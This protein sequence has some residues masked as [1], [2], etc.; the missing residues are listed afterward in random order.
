MAHISLWINVGLDYL[1]SMIVTSFKSSSGDR[2]PDA[3]VV[4]C[5]LITESLIS[6]LTLTDVNCKKMSHQSTGLV[7]IC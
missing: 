6:S 3:K 4:T 1:H 5:R 7:K 2:K